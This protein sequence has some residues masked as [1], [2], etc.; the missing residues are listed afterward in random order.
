[1]N[2]DKIFICL[3][4]VTFGG[5]K[6][7]IRWY[8]SNDLGDYSIVKP[9]RDRG[10]NIRKYIVWKFAIYTRLCDLRYKFKFQVFDRSRPDE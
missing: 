6:L 5:S 4:T 8:I 1:M 9:V 10:K 7:E 3:Q 2:I